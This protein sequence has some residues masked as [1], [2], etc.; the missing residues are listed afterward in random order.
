MLL[1][2]VGNLLANYDKTS[3]ETSDAYLKWAEK[4]K[5]CGQWFV[6]FTSPWVYLPNKQRLHN[7]SA[8]LLWYTILCKLTLK[9]TEKNI[10][11]V[12]KLIENGH[13]LLMSLEV[14][15]REQ[16]CGNTE[17]GGWLCHYRLIY[18]VVTLRWEDNFCHYR[19]FRIN[20]YYTTV[21]LVH[22]ASWL[23]LHHN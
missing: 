6:A 17:T 8:N 22:Y 12:K 10:D 2:V 21:K 18:F 4:Y 14:K 7:D 15:A 9:H 3:T 1:V 23:R 20:L 13:I 5:A 19:P 16:R 11:L